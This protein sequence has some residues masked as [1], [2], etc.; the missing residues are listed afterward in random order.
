MR[1]RA[2]A[3]AD[4]P[5]GGPLAALWGP[6]PPSPAAAAGPLRLAYAGVFLAQTLLALAVALTLLLVTGA[7]PR[8][9]DVMAGV[10]LGMAL[11][12]VPLG[13]ALG[14]A[15]SGAPGRGAGLAGA[16]GAGVALSVTAW[17]AA[18]AFVSGQRPPWLVAS[19]GVVALAYLAGFA[20]TPR[21]ARAAARADEPT[22]PDAASG[23]HGDEVADVAAAPA[24]GAADPAR[25][26]RRP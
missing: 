15:A 21:F 5:R 2:A 14:Y 18:L 24:V 22:T 10:L 13:V 19:V 20:L 17:F 11:L 4:R 6:E 7:R 16:L 23:T 1:A 8:P 12:H 25:P 9:H 26:G 3:A